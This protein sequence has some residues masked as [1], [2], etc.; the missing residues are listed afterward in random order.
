MDDS[1]DEGFM[2]SR[3]E[4]GL[5]DDKDETRFVQVGVERVG[6]V[7]QKFP[8]QFGL[9]PW[10]TKDFNGIYSLCDLEELK[11]VLLRDSEMIAFNLKGLNKKAGAELLEEDTSAMVEAEFKEV[12]RRGRGRPAKKKFN[13]QALTSHITQ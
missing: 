5:Y 13:S 3:E 2:A 11:E 9:S 8:S 4:C 1:G 7:K 12:R 6:R 10:S